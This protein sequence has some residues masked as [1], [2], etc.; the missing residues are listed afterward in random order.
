MN[1]PDLYIPTMAV[2]T[3]VLVYGLVLGTRN[4]FHPERLYYSSVRSITILLFELA[5]LK[6]AGF[7]LSISN[8]FALFDFIAILGY[9]FVGVIIILLS[10][11]FFGGM[12]RAIS[13]F[14]T[15]VSTFFFSVQFNFITGRFEA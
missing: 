11:L 13:L 12:G 10:T 6:A 2:V 15:S 14:Y 8:E 5:L 9:G 1:A 4:Q 3:Y 7:L